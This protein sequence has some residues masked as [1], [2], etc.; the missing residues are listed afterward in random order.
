MAPHWPACCRLPPPPMCSAPRSRQT[1][2]LPGA[3]PGRCR[4]T[5]SSSSSPA[6]ASPRSTLDFGRRR[7]LGR[8]AGSAAAG[9]VTAGSLEHS[10]A[11]GTGAPGGTGGEQTHDSLQILRRLAAE[12]AELP[13]D[14]VLPD[15][16]PL[17]ELHLSSI[18]VG[19]IMNQAARELGVSA[20]MVASAFATSTLADLAQALDDLAA[21]ARPEDASADLAPEGVAPWVR[22]FSVELVRAER[23]RRGG[24]RGRRTVAGVRFARTSAA[25]CPGQRAARRR[26]RRRRRAPAAV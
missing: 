26:D 20:P 11:P 10:A 21:T 5:R 8:P 7:R 23:P 25:R 1:R 22:A 14:T 4:W 18:T 16:H 17:D 12:R 13:L 24:R 2:C 3:L 6:R 9:P 15:S 19:Q